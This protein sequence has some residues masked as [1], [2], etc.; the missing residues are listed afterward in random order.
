VTPSVSFCDDL[1]ADGFGWIADEPMTR[2]S[3]ALALEGRV[4]LVDPLDWH[5]AIERARELG[6][7]AGVIQL[8]DRHD[9][10]CAALAERLG[11]PHLVAPDDVPSTPFEC[12]SVVRRK[13]WQER[14]LWW[15][16]TGTL[17]VADALGTNRF[18]TA[19][20]R[21][22][23]VHLLLRLTPPKS[24]GRYDSKRLLVGHG[25]AIRSDARSAIREALRTSRRDL[26]GV[27]VR[28][29]FADR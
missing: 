12:V 17:V 1:G 9:R 3:H 7:P 25:E 29:P 22:V 14:A 2:A 23:G 27:L 28:L 26:P 24:L 10:D 18:Y 8:L 20:K 19:G 16:A 11:V 5:P 13:R 6:E 4:W 15:P 21:A